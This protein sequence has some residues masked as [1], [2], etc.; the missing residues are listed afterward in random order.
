MIKIEIK[1]RFTGTV[2][3]EYSKENNTIKET[4]LEAR[5]RGAYLQG[6]YLQGA[7][8]RGADLREAD[9]Q[10]ADLRGADLQGADLQGAYLRGAYLQGAYLQGAYLQGA[11]L[12]GADLREVDLRGADLQGADLQG[13][14][15]QGAYLRGAYLRGAEFAPIKEA[16]FFTGLYNYIVIPYIDENEKR[17]KMG[18]HDRSLKEWEDDFWNN[19]SEFPIDNSESSLF[20]LM[21]FE[22]AKKWFEIVGNRNAK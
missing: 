16:A 18:C 11:Y 8:L 19:P 22:T 12:R 17:I 10:G 21:A 3:F 2:I 7:Y 15:L 20:R 14:Y 1:N 9:L 6:A 13:A 5:K 4:V